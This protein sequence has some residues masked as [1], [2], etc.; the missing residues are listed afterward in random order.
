MVK[1]LHK[2]GIE[3]LLDVVFNHTAEGDE[4]G[5]TLRFRGLDNSIYYLLDDD[6]RRYNNYSGCGNTMNCNHPVVRNFILDC[7]RY[8]VVEM[9]VDGFR[10]DLASD[11]RPRPRRR[12][13]ANP[14]LLE[15]IAED[16]ILRRR[17]IDRRGLGCGRR[18]SGGHAFP[19][20]AGPSGTACTA[21]TCAA[22]GAATRAWS[23][24]SPAGCAAAPTS[25]STAARRP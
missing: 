2:A 1:A 25:T 11:P 23:G 12:L 8:W 15:Q 10:F 6:K 17:E 4:T 14:P 20:S 3:V 21:T 24:P 7:L 22:S 18:L 16:P 19:A 5:P 13:L 9:H